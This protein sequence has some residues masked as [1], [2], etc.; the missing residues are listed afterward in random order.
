VYELY[1]SIPNLFL[2]QQNRRAADFE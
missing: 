1:M 2:T